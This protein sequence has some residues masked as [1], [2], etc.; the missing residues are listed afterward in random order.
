MIGT[1]GTFLD[2]A[3]ES[4]VGARRAHEGGRY[5]NSANRSYYAVFQAAI[6]AIL[7]ERISPP[8][9][10]D[11]W[12]HGWVQGQ[13]NGLLIHRRHLYSTDLRTVL[14]D[15]Y[16]LRVRADYTTRA[17]TEVLASRALQRAERFV[18]AIVQ[19]QERS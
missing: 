4:L 19:R 11:N 7:A 8:G 1:G 9:R 16:E 17:V 14:S 10:G 13:F 18:G 3:Q 2:K 5:S 6:H 12:D 15:N